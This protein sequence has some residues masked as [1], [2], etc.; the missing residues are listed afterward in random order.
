MWVR[1][2]EEAV[3]LEAAL[4]DLPMLEPMDENSAAAAA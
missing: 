4:D 1:Q 2:V 3:L